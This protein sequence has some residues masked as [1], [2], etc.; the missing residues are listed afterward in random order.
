MPNFAFKMKTSRFVVFNEKV[1]RLI[2]VLL[3]SSNLTPKV[4]IYVYIFICFL[5]NISS[6]YL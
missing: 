3:M 6:I 4:F 2:T 5:K 1:Y